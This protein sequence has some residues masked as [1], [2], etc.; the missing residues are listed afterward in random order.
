MAGPRLGNDDGTFSEIN[1]TPF[2]DVMLVL[3]IIFMV[4]APMLQQGIDVD[5]PETTTQPL[6]MRD[7]PLILTVKK[8]GTYHLA[9]SEIPLAELQ[10]KLEAI[11]EG[12]DDKEIY[13]RA[14]QAAPY[15]MVVKAMAA[16]RLAGAQTVG[17]VTEPE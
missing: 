7:E 8:E 13:L 12:L 14:D 16:A 4:T 15:G 11:F 2:V 3:L 10:P 9:N 5:L 1:V 6:R 17:I